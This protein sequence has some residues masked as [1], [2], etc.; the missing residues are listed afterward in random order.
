M[1]N[2][3]RY[4]R[5]YGNT[6]GLIIKAMGE[7]NKGERVLW[8]SAPVHN[9]HIM[10][11]HHFAVQKREGV[12]SRKLFVTII[13]LFCLTVSSSVRAQQSE[14]TL[15]QRSNWWLVHHNEI[16]KVINLAY[17]SWVDGD[18][19]T[20]LSCFTP[21]VVWYWTPAADPGSYSVWLAGK[22]GLKNR[23]DRAEEV[24][25]YFSGRFLVVRSI[26]VLPED[27]EQWSTKGE[28]GNAH[29]IA[30]AKVNQTSINKETGETTL[31]PYMD[32]Y[33]MKRIDGKWMI[34]GVIREVMATP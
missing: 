22:D 24:K 33:M 10:K 26:N 20:F 4:Q 31:H 34:S 21:D 32:T 30:V 23:A 2:H 17:Y 8:E 12:M 5:G 28:A 13:V 7:C 14:I 6:L 11:G 3:Q 29:G 15:V 18:G 9:G 27:G 19:D 25:K 1:E 16:E